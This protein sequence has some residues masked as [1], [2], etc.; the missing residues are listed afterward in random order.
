MVELC[1]S[2]KA[3]PGLEGAFWRFEGIEAADDPELEEKLRVGSRTRIGRW[4]RSS[5]QSLKKLRVSA[6]VTGAV[7]N[8]PS[9]SC[10]FRCWL[11]GFLIAKSFTSRAI[12][13]RLAMSKT[14]DPSGTAIKAIEHPR[15]AW[16][17]R[18]ASIWVTMFQYRFGGETARSLQEIEKLQ[19]VSI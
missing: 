8:F 19:V 18:K 2:K 10:T 9:M 1:F 13:E 17:I 6:A 3:I 5:K 15:L 11:N 7:S 14:N 4:E 12:R 16:F